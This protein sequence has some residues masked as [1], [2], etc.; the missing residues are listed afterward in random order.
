MV[1]VDSEE[2]CLV[3]REGLVGC[4]LDNEATVA[5]ELSQFLCQQ[6][7]EVTGPVP[8][9]ELQFGECMVQEQNEFLAGRGAW[10]LDLPL[11]V[12]GDGSQFIHK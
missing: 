12:Y 9:K 4:V 6:S 7:A 10:V 11:K 5:W 1:G 8:G 3:F 2:V